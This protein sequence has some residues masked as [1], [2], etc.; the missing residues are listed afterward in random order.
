MPTPGC[1]MKIIHREG[2]LPETVMAKIGT[3]EGG[4][5]ISDEFCRL[6]GPGQSRMM[7]A[8]ERKQTASTSRA[9]RVPAQIPSEKNPDPIETPSATTL[10]AGYVIQ[11]LLLTVGKRDGDH[12][13]VRDFN[14]LYGQGSR[15][16]RRDENDTK[17]GTM[18]TRLKTE[19][20]AKQ[21]GEEHLQEA[22]ICPIMLTGDELLSPGELIIRKARR[23]CPGYY[24]SRFADGYLAEITCQRCMREGAGACAGKPTAVPG[25]TIKVLKNKGGSPRIRMEKIGVP[26]GNSLSPKDI[27]ELTGETS[28]GGEA[29]DTPISIEPFNDLH[30]L[31]SR[32][33]F[34]PY[35]DGITATA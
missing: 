32:Y 9:E 3:P 20:E 27:D 5:F 35:K 11:D 33:V 24:S 10:P 17:T 25:L 34:R 28:P 15:F 16:W 26:G 23:S 18:V 29:D 13:M 22:I 21:D 8:G 6:T 7:N 1:V 31:G 12:N 4:N 2:D 19:E 30:G 14:D